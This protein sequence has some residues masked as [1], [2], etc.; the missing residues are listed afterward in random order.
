[1]FSG[2]A[3]RASERGGGGRG[4]GCGGPSRGPPGTRLRTRGGWVGLGG[5]GGV[6]FEPA[7]TLGL[8]LNP[9]PTLARGGGGWGGGGR[10]GGWGGEG[11]EGE[12]GGGAGF[13][14]EP[15]LALKPSPKL[16][17]NPWMPVLISKNASNVPDS[18]SFWSRFFSL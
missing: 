6:G 8:R 12:G 1:M 18:F 4:Q 9:S 17:P 14:P 2:G 5:R 16:S 3:P 10:G 13:E 11:E 7:L 15:A